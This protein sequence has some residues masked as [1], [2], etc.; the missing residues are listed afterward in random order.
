MKIE[1]TDILKLIEAECCKS[2]KSGCNATCK[3]CNIRK[4]M[5]LIKN[6]KTEHN[7]DIYPLTIV[8]DRYNGT[9]S[10]GKYI[11]W[12]CSPYA[13]PQTTYTDDAW[14]AW[15]NI[16]GME[17]NPETEYPLFGVGD[18]IESAISNLANK[19][20]NKKYYRTYFQQDTEIKKENKI[21]IDAKS[22]GCPCYTCFDFNEKLQRCKDIQKD[23]I[24]YHNWYSNTFNN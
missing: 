18:T 11:A 3:G 10:K 7:T 8:K 16:Y 12:N 6:L 20:N 22:L 14:Y 15:D 1:I 19:L 24:E 23:C 2:C 17:N 4:I 9:Y 21:E 13:V 5:D